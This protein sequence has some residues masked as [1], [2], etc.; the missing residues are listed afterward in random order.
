[1]NWRVDCVLASTAVCQCPDGVC[2]NRRVDALLAC[3]VEGIAVCEPVSR[4]ELVDALGPLI[5]AYSNPQSNNC[6]LSKLSPLPPSSAFFNVVV[7]VS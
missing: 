2:V 5:A 7:I 3:V 4:V 1:M 6:D